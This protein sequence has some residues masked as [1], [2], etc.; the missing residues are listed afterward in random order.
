MGSDSGTF[1]G[2]TLTLHGVST[3]VYFSERPDRKAGQTSLPSFVK[4]WNK[5]AD[6]FEMDH[7][8]AAISLLDSDPVHVILELIKPLD[9][10]DDSISFKVK[11]LP[12]GQGELPSRFGPSSTVID[13]F[14]TAVNSQI[15]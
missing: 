4:M 15:T 14:P 3:V 5:G 6:N 2:K 1:D 9:A 12:G 7:P 11:L 13:A 8:N 10:S